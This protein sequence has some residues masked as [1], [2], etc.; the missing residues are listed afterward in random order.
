MA[1]K[2]AKAHPPRQL[3]DSRLEPLQKGGGPTSGR[4][5]FFN[6]TVEAVNMAQ[7]ISLAIAMLCYLAAIGC[8]G[9]AFHYHGELGSQHPIVASLGAS[10]VFFIGVGIVLHVIGRADI[11]S[12]R[13]DP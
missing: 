5:A 4:S 13:I 8:G 10:V 12:L 11:P 6:T 1:R 9:A 7:K 2:P 3:P